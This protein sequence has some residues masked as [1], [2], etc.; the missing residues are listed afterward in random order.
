MVVIKP[1]P[2]DFR[3]CR[4]LVLIAGWVGAVD[5]CGIVLCRLVLVARLG[6]D[7]L[8]GICPTGAAVCPEVARAVGAVLSLLLKLAVLPIPALSSPDSSCLSMPGRVDANP[9][10][11]AIAPPSSGRFG[12]ARPPLTAGNS[13]SNGLVQFGSTM[14]FWKSSKFIVGT[15]SKASGARSAGVVGES[16]PSV[17]ECWLPLPKLKLDWLAA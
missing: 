1:G 7:V 17:E 9:L 16:V 2:T 4:L 13:L 3:G 6:C 8:V 11:L 12:S 14:L 15:K 5:A 10:L